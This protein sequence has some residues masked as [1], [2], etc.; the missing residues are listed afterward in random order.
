MATEQTHSASNGAVRRA[1]LRTIPLS[2]IVVRDGFNPRGEIVENDELEAMAATMRERG[3]LQSI[4]VRLTESGDFQL[5]AGE[6]RY[7]AAALAA[8]TEMPALV[9]PEG[10]G[11]EAEQLELLTEAV[12]ENEVRSDLDP[13]QRAQGFQAMI[14]CGLNVRGVAE[15]L[16][17]KA[18]RTSRERRIKAHLAILAL[19]QDLR[20]QVATEAIPLAA[21]KTLAELCKIH[22]DL[23]RTAVAAASIDDE[24][25]RCSWS[26]VAEHGLSIAV[27]HSDTLPPGIY[28]SSESYPLEMFT[29]PAQAT[30]DLA[31][32]RKIVGEQSHES[33]CF[34]P[35]LVEQA[36]V[37]GAVHS[38][39]AWAKLI[40]GQDVADQL[41]GDAIARRLKT[42]RAEQRRERAE[43]KARE[44]ST[45][46]SGSSRG[47]A[48][49]GKSETPEERAAREQ[50]QAKAERKASQEKRDQAIA[51]NEA[52][53]LL[54]FKHLPKIKVDERVLRI[55]ASVRLGGDLRGIASR[56]AR[57][58]LP[59]WIEHGTKAK[60]KPKNVYLEAE[61][62]GRRAAG[63]LADAQ[64][65]GDIAG[66]ALTLIALAS[67]V[68]E[69]AIAM[70]RRSH[71]RLTFAGPWAGQ[72]KRDLNAIVRE[73]IKE[74]QLP[75]LDTI[76]SERIADDE[77]QATREVETT[78]A[79]LRLDGVEERKGDLT[80][81][82]LE[83]AVADAELVY[84]EHSIKAHNLRDEQERR[85]AVDATA[86]QPSD[87]APAAAGA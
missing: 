17:G 77:E 75:E 14:D 53:G 12:I 45:P 39:G 5:V 32:Y 2:R 78:K 52:L 68:D 18:K 64:S 56:G 4:R 76:L 81:D 83:Q 80:L 20:E 16:G 54:F 58:A 40:V 24:Y 37:L 9:L 13:L 47:K 85:A 36:H 87:V 72:A 86:E 38:M 51:F 73:R 30:K 25:E 29:L 79:R 1:E 63:F 60:G 26:E 19:P 46:G 62:A 34:T 71:Y 31:S 67:L 43:Q 65:S 8:L 3:C 49:K 82:E 6:R 55:L 84:G 33:I 22:E 44:A 74:G 42:A 66:R 48:Q 28:Q 35:E 21:V 50:E 23:A 70:S 11:D 61:D 59:A 57:L 7:R 15:R 41:A 27:I 10:T 69:E